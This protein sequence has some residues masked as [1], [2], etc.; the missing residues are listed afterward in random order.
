VDI[1]ERQQR[2]YSFSVRSSLMEMGACHQTPEQSSLGPK[3]RF[4]WLIVPRDFV[5]EEMAPRMHETTSSLSSAYF[6][7]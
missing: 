2:R 3:C 1:D 6:E 7:K 4:T 5:T